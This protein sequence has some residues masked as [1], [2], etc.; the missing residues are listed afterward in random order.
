MSRYGMVGS[1]M[2]EGV[3][4]N[5]CEISFG[6]GLGSTNYLRGMQ[7]KKWPELC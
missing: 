3:V 6:E 1:R 7:E 4:C 2:P 5:V